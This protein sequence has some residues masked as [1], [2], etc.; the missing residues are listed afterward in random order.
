VRSQEFLTALMYLRGDVAESKYESVVKLN[1]K[2]TIGAS[3]HWDGM[4]ARQSRLSLLTKL[5]VASSKF[6]PRENETVFERR[7]GS[8]LILHSGYTNITDTQHSD[9]D[10]TSAVADMRA[11]GILDKN[12]RTDVA[13]GIFESSTDEIYLDTNRKYMTVNTARTQGMSAPAGSTADLRD[14]KIAAADCNANI[15]IT[16]VDGKEPIAKAK[17]LVLVLAPNSLN[18]GMSFDDAEMTRLINIGETPLLI[19]TGKYKIT[20]KNENW[21]KMRLFALNMDGSRSE[22]LKLKKANGTLEIIIDTAKTKI[23]SVYYE[24]VD[25]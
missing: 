3:V 18:S 20:L 1:E 25:L 4:D 12:N 16:S 13:A 19:E 15:T 11:R 8:S 14:V 21:K 5:S 7:G 24:L 23:P 22:E 10:L 6:E 2:E 9:F 17:R